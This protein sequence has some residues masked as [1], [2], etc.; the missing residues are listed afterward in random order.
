MRNAKRR[1]I[2][3]ATATTGVV[4]SAR[5][6]LATKTWT[7]GTSATN[8]WTDATNWGGVAPVPGSDD[9][10]FAGT[11]NTSTSNNFDPSSIFKGIT[12]DPTANSFTLGG[13]GLHLGVQATGTG[14]SAGTASSSDIVNNSTNPQ[15][16]SL[17]VTFDQGR[18]AV[19]TATT[20]LTLNG[21]VTRATG[22]T[23]AFASGGGTIDVTGSGLTNDTSDNGG[24]LGGWATIGGNFAAL[25][26]NNVDV[27]KHNNIVAYTGY[28]DY[29]GGGTIAS[30]ASNNARIPTSGAAIT[31]T[32]GTTNINTLLFA[33]T[34]AAQ[35]VTVGAGNTLVLGQNGGIFNTSSSGGTVRALT[36]ALGTLTAGDGVNPA[37]ITLSST[38]TT[39]AQRIAGVATITSA[40]TDNATVNSTAPAQVSVTVAGGYVTMNA[41]NTFSGNTYILSGRVSQAV[42][43]TFG[44]GSV[45]I[46]PGGQVNTTSAFA[47]T[48]FFIAGNGTPEQGGLGALRLFGTTTPATISSTITLMGN[49]AIVATNA[50]TPFITGKITGNGGLTIGHGNGSQGGGVISIGPASGTATPNDYTGDTTI[51]GPTGGTA[52]T[53]VSTLKINTNSTA[54][55]NNN[56]LMPHGA[57]AG[58]LI[59]D[60]AV[61]PSGTVRS[62]NFD[63][64]GTT[65]TINGLS[66]TATAP[67]NNFITSSTAGGLLVL[68][69]N[70]ASAT[71]NGII[72]DAVAGGLGL[73]KIGNG[74]QTLGG[75]NTYSGNT[76]VS[77]GTLA[78]ASTGA[79]PSST[80]VTDNANV[81]LNNASQT[82]ATLNGTG[83]M[84]LNSTALS[85][86]NGG[87]L[88]GA[89]VDGAT[90][91]SVTIAGGTMVLAGANTYSGNTTVNSGATLNVTGSLASTNN[92]TANGPVNFGVMGSTAA[93]TQQLTS[94]TIAPNITA[95]ITLSNDASKPKTLQPAT[96]TFQDTTTSKLDISNNILISQGTVQQAEALVTNTDP[97]HPVVTSDS[98]LALGY[99][100]A[101]SGNYEIRATLLGDSDL[102]GK[103]NVADLAN[104]AGNFGKTAGQFWL[105]GDFD[106]NGNV[107]VADLA[108]LAG[109][110]GK[111]LGVGS[112]AGGGS[113][114]ASA[115]VVA[116]VAA[117]PE[118]GS[119]GVIG[120]SGAALLLRRRRRNS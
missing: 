93:S 87:S 40:I 52:T 18:H 95:S 3:L 67:G 76:T 16:I 17:G 77:A 29:A 70:N 9:L 11:N 114:A 88:S 73:S 57:A 22:S 14:L 39:D 98:T 45:F 48:P 81:A 69:D 21:A 111:Q 85:I 78:V 80:N 115:A 37:N 62:A 63:L 117:V 66:S 84:T 19:T 27:T 90:A 107:N 12:F 10:I 33:G 20:G 71:Y 119:F 83:G 30:A 68:G 75:V 100:D 89:I 2:V 5:N 116:G 28:T 99:K 103:V 96:L 53:V 54:V 47:T 74:T 31:T 118:P 91:G 79:L 101:G 42:T 106:Y 82:F 36:V 25:D 32:A 26:V 7:G 44:T 49:A 38:A 92:V 104:L 8:T 51:S 59:L 65:Q 108:D 86:N 110:F 72:M 113:A 15:T 4:L 61:P 43:S 34:T 50:S 105:N 55:S 58:N 64:N 120:V 41:A 60:A 1:M 109:N 112:D 35:T 13:A 56:N 23:V 24:I 97:N 102:D 6:A 46:Y 94:L